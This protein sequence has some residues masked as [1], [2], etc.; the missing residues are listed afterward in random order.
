MEPKE[1]SKQPN[2]AH[3]A[4]GT[5]IIDRQ[6]KLN[7]LLNALLAIHNKVSMQ[8][9]TIPDIKGKSRKME[10]VE[11]RRFVA[12]WLMRYGLSCTVAGRILG[13][14]DHSTMIHSRD[15]YEELYEQ[16][17]INRDREKHLNWANQVTQLFSELARNQI[18]TSI[19]EIDSPQPNSPEMIAK[20]KNEL[21]E[22]KTRYGS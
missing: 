19:D 7:Y 18:R 11:A 20:F 17:P 5:T 15:R 9:V 2:A 6:G 10:I 13:S 16:S 8:G 21:I 12:Y 4:V 3:I 22:I 1:L 14:R